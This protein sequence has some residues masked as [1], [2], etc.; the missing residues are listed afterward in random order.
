[1]TDF[2]EFEDYSLVTAILPQ[3]STRKVL[4]AILSSGAP[5]ALAANARGSIIKNYWYQSLLPALSPEQEILSFLVPNEEC[6]HLMEQV[7]MEGKLQQ[8]GAGSIY[9]TP[10]DHL[11]CANDF[12]IWTPG[13]YS[14]ESV[15]YDIQFKKELS[16]LVLITEKGAADGIARAAIRAGS[17]GPTISYVRG[18]GLLYR[19][20]LLRITKTHDK[21][22]ITAVVDRYDVDA[23]FEAMAQAGKIDRPGR[24]ILYEVPISKGL[25]NLASVF[26]AQKHSAS[27]QQI[28]RAID[29]IQGGADWRAN[30]LLIHDPEAEEIKAHSKQVIKTRCIFT[31]L[32]HRKDTDDLLKK[33]LNCGVPGASIRYWRFA[34]ANAE[35]TTGGQRI[36]QETGSITMI[37]DSDKAP[38][39]Q[40]VLRE[41]I[42]QKELKQA[43]IFSHAASAMK[44]YI[45]S[46]AKTAKVS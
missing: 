43:C 11:T 13:G 9:A 14:F 29:E 12:P 16:A 34:Q 3:S 25:T 23:V 45:S 4:E 32:C 6:D 36:N 28:V 2:R 38:D 7:V 17:P 21:E 37:V 22:Q 19:L 44:T 5:H 40:R 41:Y 39:L 31:I 30:H 10:C 46:K 27:I 20:W 15:S 1:M 24:G 35:H 33:S 8:F 42:V 18:Y 26:H